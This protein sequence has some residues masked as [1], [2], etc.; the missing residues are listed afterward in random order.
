MDGISHKTIKHLRRIARAYTLCSALAVAIYAANISTAYATNSPMTYVLCTILT[1]LVTGS[2]P[3]GLT[4]CAIIMLG[5]GA[6]LG[7]VSWGLAVTVAVG[8][9][10]MANAINIMYLL[11]G[12]NVTTYC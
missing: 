11:T 3:R 10:I 6:T 1:W 4:T 7:K 2:L 12:I 8:I 5:I 9:A